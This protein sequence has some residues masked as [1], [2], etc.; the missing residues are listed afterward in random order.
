MAAASTQ[1]LRLALNST[2][3]PSGLVRIRTSPARAQVLRH[4]RSGWTMPVTDKPNFGS[5]SFMVWP[6]TRTA[7][8][9]VIFSS[10]PATIPASTSGPSFDMGKPTRFRQVKGRPPMAYTSLRALAAAMRPKTTGS[11]T[12][13][14]MISAVCTK[15]VPASRRY[16][17]ASSP[18]SN[19]TNR[20]GS[21]VLGKPSSNLESPTGLT[22]A[23]QP[24]VLARLV[25]VLPLW[26]RLIREE[27]RDTPS[28]APCC[29]PHRET[30]E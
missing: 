12:G 9:S 2:P 6:P 24:Q 1:P 22:F 11:S 8:A 15:A 18:V 19:P 21:V 3:V 30:G 23:A 27:Y 10:A 7:P 16:T 26:N 5:S 4:S 17:P 14:V 28:G 13:G 20:F 25:S 29:R